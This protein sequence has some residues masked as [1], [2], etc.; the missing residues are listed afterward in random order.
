VDDWQPGDRIVLVH[1]NY[2]YTDLEP[3][4]EGIVS[5]Q[6]PITRE[7]LVDWDSGAQQIM[8]P[9]PATSSNGCDRSPAVGRAI[10]SHGCPTPAGG[11]SRDAPARRDRISFLSPGGLLSVPVG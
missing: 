11:T 5:D 6:T 9:V 3:G 2:P 8:L 1:A 7:L 10:R 4:D